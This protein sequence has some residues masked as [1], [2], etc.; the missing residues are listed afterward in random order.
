[1]SSIRS[2][3]ALWGTLFLL[4]LCAGAASAQTTAVSS[5][6]VIDSDGTT[7]INANWTIAFQPNSNFPNPAI[8]TIN[9]APLSPSVTAQSGT[10]SSG[11]VL[12]VT[13]YD[14]T[15]VTPAG[16][17]WVLRVCPLASVG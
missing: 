3:L 14:N 2:K 11:G 1:M 16:S 13:V 4:G 17:S 9:G 15:Q 5:T 12:A 10:L 7:W 6:G 8:Y